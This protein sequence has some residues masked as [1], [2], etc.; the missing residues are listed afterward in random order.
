VSGVDG[1]EGLVETCLTGFPAVDEDAAF[2]RAD[3]NAGSLRCVT[4]DHQPEFFG[5]SRRKGDLDALDAAGCSVHD[6]PTLGDVHRSEVHRRGG[7]VCVQVCGDLLHQ[8]QASVN[9][10]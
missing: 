1:G 6:V 5:C 2:R 3:A 4:A 10:V 9:G 7:G 8:P